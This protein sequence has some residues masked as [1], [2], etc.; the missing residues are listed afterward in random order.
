MFTPYRLCITLALALVSA[1]VI[2]CKHHPI[3]PIPLSTTDAWVIFINGQ[4]N[5]Q[6]NAEL[7]EDLYSPMRE[8]APD[9][10]KVI[11]NVNIWNTQAHAWQPLQE[12]VNSRPVEDGSYP[13]GFTFAA[14]ADGSWD[15]GN[16]AARYTMVGVG[17]EYGLARAWQTIHPDAKLY[18]IKYSVG[19]TSLAEWEKSNHKLYPNFLKYKQEAFAA[20]TG[21][22]IHVVGFYRNQGE[23]DVKLSTGEYND[24]LYQFYQD[25][26]S[27]GFTTD[28]TKVVE[29]GCP[30]AS[31][32]G[33]P[34]SN[35][36]NAVKQ[37]FVSQDPDHRFYLDPSFVALE[38]DEIHWN[39][40]SQYY[41][42][43]VR[44]ANIFFGA[45][46]TLQAVTPD[47]P[48]LTYDAADHAAVVVPPTPAWPKKEFYYNLD[49][50]TP[51]RLTTSWHIALGNQ[52]VAPG[53][54][55]VW[56]RAVPGRT[57]SAEAV[58]S[59]TY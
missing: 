44:L 28:E 24:E 17:P 46:N 21:K 31:D 8:L 15:V 22:N 16:P 51:H 39:L 29:A 7:T 33:T 32:T 18:I 6:G 37:R 5:A 12:G 26:A 57:K 2:A 10:S 20:L 54:L 25:L 3:P 40:A 36:Q 45:K 9:V 1:G 30:I 59:I 13:E 43:Y 11:P 48:T 47:G 19:G 53:H 49:G 56:I 38:H 14:K 41:T 58:N 52:P 34:Y 35:P 23:A 50:G 42:G 27:D 4:S 55:K